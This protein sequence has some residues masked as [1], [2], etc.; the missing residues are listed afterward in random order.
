MKYWTY[1]L[2]L[3]LRSCFEIW[4]FYSKVYVKLYCPPLSITGTTFPSSSLQCKQYPSSQSNPLLTVYYIPY[5][6]THCVFIITCF[7][8]LFSISL[9]CWEGPV[10]TC[11]RRMCRI[12]CDLMF[13]QYPISYTSVTTHWE[14]AS[15]SHSPWSESCSL[16][17]CWLCHCVIFTVA[18]AILFQSPSCTGPIE[19]LS[20]SFSSTLFFILEMI[21]RIQVHTYMAIWKRQSWYILIKGERSDW[22]VG[23]RWQRCTQ[24]SVTFSKMSKLCV[25]TCFIPYAMYVFIHIVDISSII[26]LWEKTEV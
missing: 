18:V 23:P 9:H 7:I 22:M 17:C 1:T 2:W 21:K 11:L 24:L 20:P 8:S 13:H 5:I 15:C 6:I 26:S 3:Y 25:R 19:G 4:A 12:K 14:V 10:Y 16:T